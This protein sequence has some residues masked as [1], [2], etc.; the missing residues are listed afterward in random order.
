MTEYNPDPKTDQ[1]FRWKGVEPPKRYSTGL[2]DTAENPLSEQPI[3][4]DNLKDH[5]C[6]WK[7]SGGEIYCEVGE[8]RH[9]KIIRPSQ[10]LVYVNGKPKVVAM[11]A[12]YRDT[13]PNWAKSPTAATR[14]KQLKKEK[15]NG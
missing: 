12:I 2:K 3:L 1:W 7:Q 9:G 6:E 4:K 10:R 14:R 13:K 15:S 8:F 5:V 11:K